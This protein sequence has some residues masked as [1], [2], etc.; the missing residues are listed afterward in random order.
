MMNPNVII[1]CAVTG[2][3]SSVVQKHPGLPRT[4]KQ[5]AAAAIGAAQAGAAIVHIHV[6][7][8]ETGAP[9]NAPYLYREVVERIRDD[10]TDVVINLTTGMGTELVLDPHNPAVSTAG[11]EMLLPEDRFRHVEELRP[12]ICTLDLATLNLGR[13]LMVNTNES[14]RYIAERTTALG[15]KPELEIF[16]AGDIPI[17]LQLMEEGLIES[18]PLFQLC[19][20]L[21]G[22]APATPEMML[23]LARMLPAG[24]VWGGFGISRMEFPMA[25]QAVLLGGH[26]RVGLEDNIYLSRGVLATNEQLVESA[27]RLIEGIGCRVVAPDEARQI[28]GLGK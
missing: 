7:D 6:R 3:N 28:L 14:I 18:P 25:V 11:T 2:A 1:T 19:L 23:A 26:V 22:G 13:A 8:P 15:V 20:G 4:P 5:I 24:S 27:V 21:R 9:S 16:D 10:Q 17:A 12:E